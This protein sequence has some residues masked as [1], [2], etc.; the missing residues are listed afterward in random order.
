M[1]PL[2]TYPTTPTPPA[3]APVPALRVK[4]RHRVRQVFGHFPGVERGSLIY[5]DLNG[6]GWYVG[7]AGYLTLNRGHKGICRTFRGAEDGKKRQG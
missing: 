5:L 3:P 2:P 6:Y 1:T 4:V 7:S